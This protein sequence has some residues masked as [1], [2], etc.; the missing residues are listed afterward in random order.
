MRENTER[1]FKHCL[2][3]KNFDKILAQPL[4]S[5][6]LQVWKF[7]KPAINRTTIA[8]PH[9]DT[10]IARKHKRN[11]FARN[12]FGTRRCVR[13]TVDQVFLDRITAAAHGTVI[14]PRLPWKA[15]S[16][17]KFHERLIQSRARPMSAFTS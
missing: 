15:D 4:C 13:K 6:A 9:E 17:A 16:R 5:N 11:K 2:F 1:L 14:A 3:S 7:P 10:S 12:R 8:P